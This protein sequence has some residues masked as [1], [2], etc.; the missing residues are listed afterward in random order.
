MKQTSPRFQFA[1][2]ASILL[3]SFLMNIYL[4]KTVDNLR[5]EL[6]LTNGHQTAKEVLMFSQVLSGFATSLQD[7]INFP[8]PQ[9]RILYI[10]GIKSTNFF[11]SISYLFNQPEYIKDHNFR[12]AQNALLEEI[13]I[14]LDVLE[15]QPVM[16]D[17]R[18]K[19][20]ISVLEQQS[21]E[22][23]EYVNKF[24]DTIFTEPKGKEELYNRLNAI[25]QTLRKERE[26]LNNNA[27]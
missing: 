9:Q 1:V 12:L 27:D 11:G 22:L 4:A 25:T 20:V 15:N 18:L 2:F 19:A 14:F 5:K 16:E 23:W 24:D 17:N 8:N 21:K 26:N 6:L 7:Y 10:K 3:F 13:S